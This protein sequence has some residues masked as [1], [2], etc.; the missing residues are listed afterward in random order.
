MPHFSSYQP[1]AAEF[2]YLVADAGTLLITFQQSPNWQE[3]YRKIMLLGKELPCLATEFRR[4]EAKVNGCE[5]DA[6]LYHTIQNGKHYYLADSDARIVKGLIGLLLAACHG[7]TTEEIH[8]FNAQDYFKQLG[9]AG[10]LSPSRTN[11]L[12][13]LA[14]AMIKATE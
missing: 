10:Q 1:N 8:H 9:L 6:W 3:R 5:S 13:A 2:N 11:G 14:N 4:D 7:K 12:H